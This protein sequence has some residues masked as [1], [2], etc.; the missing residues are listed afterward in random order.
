MSSVPCHSMSASTSRGLY[1]D[2][3]LLRVIVQHDEVAVGHVEARQV[4][5]GLLG[6]VDVLK[7]DVRRAARLLGAPAARTH[8]CMH[9]VMRSAALACARM[10]G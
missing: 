9:G 4:V 5:A 2:I 1:L 10:D 8:A 3:V 7:H 6:V